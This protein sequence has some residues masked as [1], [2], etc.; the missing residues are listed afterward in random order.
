MAGDG[1]GMTR[2]LV[3]GG[4]YQEG[5]TDVDEGDWFLRGERVVL[6]E[7][8]DGGPESSVDV[9]GEEVITGPI[10][11]R[12]PGARE[13]LG[14]F[15]RVAFEPV[16][17]EEE[18]SD[19]EWIAAVMAGQQ[20]AKGGGRADGDRLRT[21]RRVGRHSFEVMN[22]WVPLIALGVLVFGAVVTMTLLGEPDVVREVTRIEWTPEGKE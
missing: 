20:S 3:L 10:W 13:Y 4:E 18:V 16:E 22:Q 1:D 19:G 11:K 2:V 6:V 5:W 12:V 15:K 7:G 14:Q 21:L 17:D 9:Y 8:E